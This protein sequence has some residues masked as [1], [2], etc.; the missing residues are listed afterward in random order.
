MSKRARSAEED[1]VTVQSLVDPVRVPA[2]ARPAPA[3]LRRRLGFAQLL[4]VSVGAIIGSAWLFAP[5]FAAQAAGPAAIVAWLISGGAALLLALVYA[6]LGAAFP[7]AGGLARFSY[8]S[9]GNLAGFVA[10]IACWLGYVAIAPIEV[11][12]M[13]RYLSDAAPWLVTETAA[14]TLSGWGIATSVVLLAAMS[15]VNLLGVQWLGEAN[16]YLTMWKI[17]VPVLVAVS[18]LWVSFRGENFVAYGGAMPAG[19]NGVFAAVSTGGTLFAMLGFR[20]AIEMAGEATDPQRDIPRA[21]IGSVLITCAI[22]VLIQVAFIGALS[23]AALA[24]GWS[25]L[26]GDVL[27]GPLV[28]LAA[29]AGLGW[30]VKLLYVDSSV[31]PG[32]CGLVFTGAAARLCYAMAQNGQLPAAFL[33]LDRRGIPLLALGVNFAVGLVF[34]APSQTWQSIVSFIS[35]IQILSLAFGPPALLALRRS[36]PDVARPF[37]LPAPRLLCGVAFFTANTIVYWCGW[38]TN[39]ACLAILVGLGVLFVAVKKVSSPRERL[40]L[41]GLAWLAPYAIGL[42]AV[43]ALGQ[44]G[45]GAKVV[46]AG[47]DLVLLAVLSV[48]V[49]ALSSFG[50]GAGLRA[51]LDTEG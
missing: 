15:A 7:V 23:P 40:D 4:F 22:Y 41:V 33:R 24:G 29:A 12:A 26:S 18:L 44:F 14:H 6:E 25:A 43:S 46:P 31:S 38:E 35:S 42:A 34:F 8:F 51:G 17:V 30:L 21:L 48:A 1:D 19:W 37:R 49:L 28:G 39:R 47:V 20:T 27:A 5:L 50:S 3:E 10:G 36:A 11:Q 13:V 9:H 45:A 16:R 32:G 2:Q